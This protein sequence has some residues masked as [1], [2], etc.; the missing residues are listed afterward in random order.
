[1][2]TVE[3]ELVVILFVF[4]VTFTFV[5]TEDEESES[6]GEQE[7]ETEK[8]VPITQYSFTVL[9]E[10]DVTCVLGGDEIVKCG[11]SN[12]SNVCYAVQGGSNF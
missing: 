1:M 6:A 2:I 12:E 7:Q 9:L 3:Y 11:H 5:E 4:L 8:Y 10:S